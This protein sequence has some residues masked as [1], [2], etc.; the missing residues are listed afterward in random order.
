MFEYEEPQGKDMDKIIDHDSDHIDVHGV[1]CLGLSRTPGDHDQ[2]YSETRFGTQGKAE[3][4]V[5]HGQ[6]WP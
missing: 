4:V 5:D 1:Q 3:P 2:G 6:A